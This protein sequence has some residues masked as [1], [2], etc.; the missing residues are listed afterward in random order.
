MRDK[1]NNKKPK[2]ARKRHFAK[3]ISWR[4]IGTVDTWIISFILVY[5]FGERKDSATEA[6]SFIAVFELVTKTI[7]YYFHE[8]IWYKLNFIASRQRI[9]H[10]IKTISW[11]LVGAIDT[12]ALVYIVYFMLFGNTDGASEVAISMF[13]IEI[14]TKMFLYY[15]HERIWFT[16][17]WGVIK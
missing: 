1:F 9:R 3:T 4:I 12:I 6:A 11:R 5:Y 10:I 16:S 17:N 8:R 2:I 7:L 14:I 13:S 15:V